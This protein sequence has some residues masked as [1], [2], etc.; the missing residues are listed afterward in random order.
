M[1][2]VNSSNMIDFK[3]YTLEN[4]LRLLV[5]PD[6]STPMVTVCITYDVGTRDEDPERTGFAHLFEHLMFGGSKHARNFDEYIQ[7][8]G[9]ENNAMTNQDMTVYY[10]MLP[11]ENLEVALWLEADRMAHL[12]LTKK[13]L[14][15]ERKVVVEEFKETCLEEP[16]GDIWHHI[17]PLVYTQHPYSVPTIGK[18]FK[19]IEDA[20][21]ADVETFY[22]KFYC[23]NNAILSISGKVDADEVFEKVNKW[24]GHIP[25][26]PKNLRQLPK[27]PIQTERRELHVE[28][29]VEAASLYLVFHAA[30][31]KDPDYYLDEIL[32]DVLGDG[33]ASWLFKKMVKELQIFS[34]ADAY[35]TGT[36]DTG[37]FVLEGKLAEGRNFEEA[38]AAL[39]AILARLKENKLS[40]KDLQRQQNRIEHNLEFAEV[41]AFHKAVSLGY[42]E[43]L[44]DANWI[45]AEGAHYR[46]ISVEAIQNRA[47]QLF[48]PHLASVIYYHPKISTLA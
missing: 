5:H 19:H 28:A 27:E 15:K 43:L 3:K 36:L 2:A 31:R 37:L 14:D 18:T 13:A 21:L 38:E 26:G 8:A 40:E 12:N 6:H 45:N 1:Q 16:Y 23:P 22:R 30:E 46:S 33:D 11:V 42:Y 20:N 35:I 41:T 48:Q 47:I 4:G 29:E 32:S 44:G 9:G 17:G 34:E 7:N 25:A 39:W 10:D 24:F